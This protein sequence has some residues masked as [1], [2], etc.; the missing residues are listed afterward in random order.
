[1]KH[2]KLFWVDDESGIIRTDYEGKDPKIVV[3]SLRNVESLSFS[4]NR[5]F[6]LLSPYLSHDASI[7]TCVLEHGVCKDHRKVPAILKNPLSIKFDSFVR[8]N[9]VDIE[10]PCKKNNGNCSDLCLIIPGNK[11]SCTCS[12]GFQLNS[13]RQSC[14][15][16]TEFMLYV[17]NN[18]VKSINLDNKN[19]EDEFKVAFTPT[20]LGTDSVNPQ[21]FDFDYDFINDDLYFVNGRNVSRTSILK[22]NEINSLLRTNPNAYQLKTISYDWLSRNLYFLRHD[23]ENHK[24]IIVAFK[25]NEHMYLADAN[26]PENVMIID[27]DS[28][29]PCLH[30]LQINVHEGN[31]FF[32]TCSIDS[33]N[34]HLFHHLHQANL[35][36]SNVEEVHSFTLGKYFAIH[37]VDYEE[38]RIYFDYHRTIYYAP[39]FSNS[40]VFLNNMTLNDN[41]TFMYVYK[42]YLYVSDSKSVWR[43]NK[44][45]G[46]NATKIVSTSSRDNEKKISAV[47]VISVVTR[48][49]NVE[50]LCAKNNGGCDEFC[51]AR[52]RRYCGCETNKKLKNDRQCAEK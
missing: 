46:A 48:S 18:F 19:Q 4:E 2:K 8:V 25:T 11:R 32:T 44:Y 41:I 15:H 35:D 12:V 5:L 14:R 20:S 43:M 23:E 39:F 51:F 38:R 22:D 13:D 21:V 34:Q 7:W 9:D 1:M 42:K 50:N 10:N 27:N 30:L 33:E 17:E 49:N 16:I 6:W 24:T 47:K 3:D 37:A 31:L 45:S 52:P 26:M 40:S 29:E 36:G 28:H